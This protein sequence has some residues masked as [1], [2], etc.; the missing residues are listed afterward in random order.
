MTPSELRFLANLRA[1]GQAPEL[2]V[3]VTD[4]WDWARRFT[5]EIGALTIRVSNARDHAHEWSPLAGLWV[6]L[7]LRR[8]APADVADFSTAILRANPAKLTLWIGDAKHVVVFDVDAKVA[9]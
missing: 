8:S 1:R 7:K 5:E 4:D 2:A 9:A 6:Y 3:F